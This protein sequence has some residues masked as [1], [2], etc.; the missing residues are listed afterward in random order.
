MARRG[1]GV[2][3]VV[4]VLAL[5]LGACGGQASE[6]PVT[7]PTGEELAADPTEDELDAHAAPEATAPP[8]D[9]RLVGAS[10]PETA[11][12]ITRETDNG[13]PVV[14]NF[15]ASWCGPCRREA[16]LLEE[17]RAANPDV[18]FLGIAYRDFEPDAA[19]FLEETGLGLPSLLDFDG[20][21]GTEM[22]VRGM[23]NTFFFDV[24]GRLVSRI[25]GEFSEDQLNARIEEA[26]RR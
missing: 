8:P 26:R 6:R 17:A 12:W 2:L 14:V 13:R 4:S 20:S 22:G 21:I 25:V 5:L 7:D 3:V 24:S 1:R 10:W 9:A 15:F 23:P 11:A 19:E 16:P 18:A